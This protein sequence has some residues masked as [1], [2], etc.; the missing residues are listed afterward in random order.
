MFLFLDSP[1]GYLS[2]N[3]SGV[4]SNALGRTIKK[5]HLSLLQTINIGARSDEG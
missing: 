1:S 2:M 5:S 3:L 4:N